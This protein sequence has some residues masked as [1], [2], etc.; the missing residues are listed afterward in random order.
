MKRLAIITLALLLFSSV[1]SAS[2]YAI[3]YVRHGYRWDGSYW[4]DSAGTAHTA[5]LGWCDDC[6]GSRYRC[7][8]YAPVNVNV[9]VTYKTTHWREQLLKIAREKLEHQEFLESVAALGLTASNTQSY[10]QQGTYSE[11]GSTVYGHGQVASTADYAAQYSAPVEMSLLYQQA[12]RLAERSQDL[13]GEATAGFSSIVQA[14]AVG[15]AEVA[16]ILAAA[17][18]VKATATPSKTEYRAQFQ[19]GRPPPSPPPV[20]A[21]DA[22]PNVA[23]FASLVAA[24]CVSCHNPTVDGGPKGGLDLSNPFTIQPESVAKMLSRVTHRDPK[25]TMPP[26]SDD[27]KLNAL[28]EDEL[29]VFFQYHV[30]R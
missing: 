21:L 3:G 28:S 11:Q 19:T 30:S 25:K 15:N 7:W 1:A 9:N 20:R 26:P 16:K 4:Y 22:R 8:R 18:V 14:Q 13:T 10:A 24:K 29:K 23:A 27:G 6:C 17:E 2:E 5:V 12:A